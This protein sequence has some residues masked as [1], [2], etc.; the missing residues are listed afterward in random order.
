MSQPPESGREFYRAETEL[1]IHYGPDTPEARQALALDRELW[2]N[3][4][5]LESAAREALDESRGDEMDGRLLAVLRW[6]DFKLDLVLYHQRVADRSRFLPH[7]ALT[8]D[9]SG[10]GVGLAQPSAEPE[11]SRV[12]VSL[13]LPD[14]PSRPVVA[15]GQVVRGEAAEG[16]GPE[17]G[18]RFV[19]ISEA[20]RERI[21]HY[22]FAKQRE[23]LSRRAGEEGR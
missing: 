1:V 15:V 20:D 12:L 11:G 18:I 10:S 16:H 9:L 14:S 3:Q 21:V 5:R 13:T 2:K 22:N 6:L 19:E 8:R 23:E 4:S 7:R 17:A